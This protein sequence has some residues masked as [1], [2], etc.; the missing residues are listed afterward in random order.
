MEHVLLKLSSLRQALLLLS[1]LLASCGQ[2]QS[3]TEQEQSQTQKQTSQTENQSQS[4][5]EKLVQYGIDTGSLIPQGLTRGDV[6]PSFRAL[7]ERG[8]SIDLGGLLQEKPVVLM[9]YRGQW[10]PVCNKY[11]KRLEDSVG[12]IRKAGAKILAVTPETRA[13]AAKMR[14]KTNSSV[15][16]IPDT[17]QAIMEAYHVGFDVTG[18]YARKIEQG[19]DV[20]IASNNGDKNARLPIPATF[21][22]NQ[23]GQIVWRFFNPDYKKR[24]SV[25]G[26]LG[27]LKKH[28]K[29]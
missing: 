11:L 28:T 27:A 16:I 25:R 10:C 9:F 14:Q 2:Q 8:D 24:A 15:T 20:S 6:A 29:L 19:F 7:T 4:V 23:D 17:S 22:I 1:V 3:Q 21:V 5:Y 26:I 18:S 12:M 13:N